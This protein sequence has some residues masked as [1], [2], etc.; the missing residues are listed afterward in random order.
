MTELLFCEGYKS[1]FEKVVLL[2][3]I[4]MFVKCRKVLGCSTLLQICCIETSSAFRIE[5]CFRFCG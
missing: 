5:R 4:Y 2:K 1:V 3:L